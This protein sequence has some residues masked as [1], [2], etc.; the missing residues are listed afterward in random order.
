M[1]QDE[2]SKVRA[3][4]KDGDGIMTPRNKRPRHRE[5]IDRYRLSVSEIN[6]YM[7]PLNGFVTINE[8]AEMCDCQ[9]QTIR[10]AIMRD[11]L[12]SVSLSRFF[13]I[14]LKSL[15]AWAK[16]KGYTISNTP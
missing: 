13:L 5:S 3:T 7:K 8:A 14:S 9:V 6:E 2:N 12:A 11:H 4:N 10:Y 15:E 1:A 16:R